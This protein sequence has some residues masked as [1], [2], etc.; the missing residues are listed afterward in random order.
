MLEEHVHQ[1]PEHVVGR[2]DQ[3]LAD[4][5]IGA[6]RL[7]H[8][9]GAELREGDRQAAARAGRRHARL[10]LALRRRL[11]EGDHDVVGLDRQLELV[12][13]GAR[14][15]GQPERRQRA[16]SDDHRMDEL[17]RDVAHVRARGGGEAG[18][19]QTPAA[20]EPLGHVVTEAR[21]PLG[22]GGEE[23]ALSRAALLQAILEQLARPA[24]R[25]QRAHAT[26]WTRLCA[27]S[28]SHSRSCVDA[29]AGLSAALDRA[30]A[31]VDD[32]DVVEQLVEV[33]VEVGE[34]VE[35]VDHDQ[36]AGPE[37][38]RVLERLVLALGQRADHRPGV[39]ADPE[40]RRADEVADVLDRSACRARAAGSGQAPSGPCWRRGGTR[41]RIRFRC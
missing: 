5:R 41:R 36:L 1:L 29:L 17:D 34:E 33:D 18:R 22:L 16:L 28:A 15:A 27:S 39:L 11:A 6:R 8:P 13:Q 31:G 35:L 12:R 37:H 14:F 25:P 3:L 21:D 24:R 9:L 26:A 30:H 2:L 4:E 10:E 40:L 38:Q 20:G 32:V 23:G 19:D 7:E